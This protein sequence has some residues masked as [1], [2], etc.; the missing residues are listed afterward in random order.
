MREPPE[1]S[2]GWFSREEMDSNDG[3]SNRLGQT[4]NGVTTHYTL[5]LASG[6]T[7]V[8]ADGTY[9]YLYGLGRIA[10]QSATTAYFHGDAL[11]S[12]RQM[13]D[14]AGDVSLAQSYRPYGELLTSQGTANSPYGFTGEWRDASGL[15]HLRARYYAPSQGRFLTRDTWGGLPYRPLSYNRWLYGYAS[16]IVYTDPTGQSPLFCLPLIGCVDT[17][18]NAVTA[19]KLAYSK[20]GP[21]VLAI[22]QGATNGQSIWRNRFIC[23][24]SR[25]SKPETA[26]ELLADY[27]CERGPEHV[28]FSGS[29][30]LTKELARSVLLDRVRK[31]FYNNPDTPYPREMQFNP[32][33][34]AL[35]ILDSF[36]A[37]SVIDPD[38]PLTHILGSFD[39]SVTKSGG[40]RLELVVTNRTD[41]AS[42]TRIPG[43]FSPNDNKFDPLS[44]EQIITDNPELENEGILRLLQD[45][46]EI[47]TILNPVERS[48][49]Q[50]WMGGGNMQQTFTWSEKLLDCG[51]QKLP[52]P[53]YLPFLGIR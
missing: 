4:A 12:V 51:L 8:L 10:Q 52:W 11:S 15:I 5:D 20:T 48:N 32:G 33:E 40:G 27:F 2:Q 30:V 13:T 14:D 46:P 47:I 17:A 49:T 21:V 45:N 25:W 26:I 6:L 18:K 29:D 41:L 9:T 34:F 28:E 42:G 43:R 24:N 3:L 7:Q 16:P 1:E 22:A 36:I 19:A 50:L 23:L 35:A 39:Y 38:F 44:V 31:E 37:G 53:V